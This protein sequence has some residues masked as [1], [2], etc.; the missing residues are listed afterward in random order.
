M[1]KKQTELNNNFNS[2]SVLIDSLKDSLYENK[3]VMV[4]I[5]E[6]INNSVITNSLYSKQNNMRNSRSR[7]EK[8]S[9]VKKELSHTDLKDDYFMQNLKQKRVFSTRSKSKEKIKLN[10]N[11]DIEKEFKKFNQIVNNYVDEHETYFDKYEERKDDY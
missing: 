7:K 1:K 3:E 9:P 8:N 6:S 2:I 4:E 11:T 5:D 10:N